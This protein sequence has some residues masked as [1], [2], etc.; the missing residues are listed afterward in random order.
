ME[1]KSG[2]IYGFIKKK[3]VFFYDIDK[4]AY[5]ILNHFIG[6]K[7]FME[8]MKSDRNDKCPCKSGKKFKKCHGPII[9]RIRIPLQNLK[10]PKPEIFRIPNAIIEMPIDEWGA[11]RNN[12]HLIY[13]RI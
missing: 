1:N 10:N 12:D 7:E 4:Q 13:Y 5:Q 6:G 3:E 2:S 8:M 11:K 9:D